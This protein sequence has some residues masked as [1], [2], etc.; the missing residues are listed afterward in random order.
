MPSPLPQKPLSASSSLS[1][2]GSSGSS[3]EANFEKRTKI[4]QELIETEQLYVHCLEAMMNC[5]RAP[6]LEW[7][8]SQEAESADKNRLLRLAG[9]IRG[10]KVTKE[11]VHRLFGNGATI[12]DLQTKLLS[13][14]RA[15]F[16]QWHATQAIGD[17][18]L[19]IAPFLRL[20]LDYSNNYTAA[21]ETLD[22]LT[23]GAPGLQEFLGQCGESSRPIC[24]ISDLK[25]FLILPIQRIPRYE[26]LLQDLISKTPE[27]H[28]DL[29]Q[30]SRCLEE[31]RI[32]SNTLDAKLQESVANRRLLD[33]AAK[34]TKLQ[35]LVAPHR[36]LV[37]EC[38]VRYF[39][40]N[41]TVSTFGMLA[42]D[43]SLDQGG[44]GV[45]VAPTASGM[46]KIRLW[47]FNDLLAHADQSQKSSSLGRDKNHWPLNLLWII[48]DNS[49]DIV[50]ES[51]RR[52]EKKPLCCGFQL[53]GPDAT[54]CL[55][56]QT[57]SAKQGLLSLIV[58]EIT[59][60]LQAEAHGLKLEDSLR[61]GEYTFASGTG[62]TYTGEWRRG[63]MHGRG[64]LRY[65]GMQYEGD[66]NK[67]ER[68]GTGRLAFTS[69]EIY[70]GDWAQ[71]QP[72][73]QGRL[74]LADGSVYLGGWRRG[75]KYG[76]G[77]L[78]YCDGDYFKGVWYDD[79]PHGN[80]VFIS[81]LRG[82]RYT[83]DWLE[84]QM[85]GP[86]TLECADGSSYVGAFAKGMKRGQGVMQYSSG[87]KYSGEW[88]D[89]RRHGT[90]VFT[91]PVA[92]LPL[93][94]LQP[95]GSSL[96]NISGGGPNPQRRLTAWVNAAEE[97]DGNWKDDIP[98]GQGVLR[99]PDGSVYEGMFRK[100]LR[101][102]AGVQTFSVGHIAKYD[103]EWVNG[104]RH[105]KGIIY[106]RN[107]YIFSGLFRNNI[108]H[109]AGILTSPNGTK[110]DGRYQLGVPEGKASLWKEEEDGTLTQLS[111][112]AHGGLLTPDKGR[113][114]QRVDLVSVLPSL[115]SCYH[116]SSG[117]S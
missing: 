116:A 2:S 18:F 86:G 106:F 12:L 37:T 97:Y 40:L 27:S 50:K 115:D 62:A 43:R 73:G 117:W 15:R 54:Y 85:E 52:K 59:R 68:S 89:N 42:L 16:D 90:G 72:D 101:H 13:D 113:L 25:N 87:A 94:N 79:Q 63:I 80:G 10:A 92:L 26:L 67:G 19:H 44:S 57:E 105:G 65:F 99:S 5:F 32:V 4:V 48:D 107:R 58:G 31:I 114:S 75:K 8:S 51:Q 112:S 69:G 30:L 66:W 28:P 84:G 3:G 17:V 102:G 55:R 46:R 21:C 11:D 61:I 109:G 96:I 108:S 24:G 71:G 49:A 100:G 103:G 7:L 76:T 93:V 104:Q 1:D 23:Q 45:E 22:K 110:L 111:G 36:K 70:E 6:I 83:G 60:T 81:P 82:I 9:K 78:L 53:V 35:A 56:F 34:V 47:L 41:S 20:Y 91:R 74:Q 98:D 64:I 14:L 77:E 39:A 88:L 95:S 33:K 38:V 29:P